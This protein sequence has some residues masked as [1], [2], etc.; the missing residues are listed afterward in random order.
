MM[1]QIEIR[2]QNANLLEVVK[3]LL[4]AS[5]CLMDAA[6]GLHPQAS[7]A[8]AKAEIMRSAGH[9]EGIAMRIG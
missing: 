1:H 4:Y 9:L 5:G 3:Q 8:D 7:L 6:T 2:E